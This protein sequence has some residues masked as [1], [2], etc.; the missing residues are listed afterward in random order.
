MEV[1]S[2]KT[3]LQKTSELIASILIM[4]SGLPEYVRMYTD[5]SQIVNPQVLSLDTCVYQIKR[6]PVFASCQFHFDNIM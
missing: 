3:V 5:M 6:T 1:L 2:L 4:V